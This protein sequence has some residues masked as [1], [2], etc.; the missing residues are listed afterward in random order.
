[1]TMPRS[2]LESKGYEYYAAPARHQCASSLLPGQTVL[3]FSPTQAGTSEDR[4]AVTTSSVLDPT[5]I[6]CDGIPIWWQASD[7]TVLSAAS[8]IISAILFLSTT[9]AQSVQ[10][11][12][13]TSGAASTRGFGFQPASSTSSTGKPQT[14]SSKSPILQALALPL[15]R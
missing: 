15:P 9:T 1:M 12:V 10:A 3:Y 4:G 11:G 8:D 5:Q 14:S 7:A 6:I 2:N 13:T